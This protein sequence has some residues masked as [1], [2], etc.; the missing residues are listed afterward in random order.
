MNCIWEDYPPNEDGQRMVR[1][2]R[3]GK[4]GVTHH[5][6]AKTFSNCEALPFWW[7]LGNWVALCLEAVYLDKFAWWRIKKA[8]GLSPKCGCVDREKKLNT[9]GRQLRDW[10]LP[11]A[12][13]S[14]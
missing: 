6:H 5:E 2:L 12:N 13:R 9:I 4:I 8:C 14:G 3:C 11:P 10:L 1:C 7:E